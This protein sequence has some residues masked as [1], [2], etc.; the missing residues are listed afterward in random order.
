M[1]SLSLYLLFKSAEGLSRECLQI[2]LPR[3]SSVVPK[4][5]LQ[6]STVSAVSLCAGTP[7]AASPGVI[8][9]LNR[10]I[11][12]C[13]RNLLHGVVLAKNHSVSG[14]IH[15]ASAKSSTPQ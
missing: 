13:S 15:R 9:N 5:R 11:S 14:K 1:I 8:N 10:L 12:D 2:K 7:S 6:E 4:H 3:S